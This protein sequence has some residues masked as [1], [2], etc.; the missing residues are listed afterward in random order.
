[1]TVNELIQQL[2]EI[3]DSLKNC[4]IIMRQYNDCCNDVIS[5]DN[6]YVEV[7]CYDDM[8]C[9]KDVTFEEAEKMDGLKSVVLA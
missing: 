1:M 9:Y 4:D 7:F 2:Q 5:I 3:P 8:L 6:V